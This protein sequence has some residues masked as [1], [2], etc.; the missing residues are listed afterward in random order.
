MKE[1]QL[2][3]SDLEECAKIFKTD[4][5]QNKNRISLLKELGSKN[6]FS[7]KISLRPIAWRLFLETIPSFSKDNN[8]IIKDWVDKILLQREEY[9]KKLKKYCSIKK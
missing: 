4:I 3:K 1:A 6:N 2:V 7:K 8:N 9:K 5:L